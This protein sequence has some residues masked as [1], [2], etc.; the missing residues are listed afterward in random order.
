MALLNQSAAA[1]VAG[2]NRSTLIRAIKSGK[3]STSINEQGERCIDTSELLRVFGPLKQGA[4]GDATGNAT[5]LPQ[6]A[7]GA[8]TS[9]ATPTNALIEVLQA[10]LQ[11][12]R[13]RERAALER[14]REGRERESRLLA[15]LEVEQAA[16][17]ELEQKLLPAP[18]VPQPDPPQR[19]HR[20][21]ILLAILA[22]A[23]TAL[24]IT[25]VAAAAQ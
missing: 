24:V 21:W 25:R 1:R 11:D 16:R 23:V 10:Q 7:S 3:L 14:E 8:N 2:I 9:D 6:S 22:L 15:L 19:H 17:R 5:P 12:A 13:E 18:P 20:L 4:T